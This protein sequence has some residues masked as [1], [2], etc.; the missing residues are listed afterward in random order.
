[1]HPFPDA[2][3]AR[4][5]QFVG[6]RFTDDPKLSP[7]GKVYLGSGPIVDMAQSDN[8]LFDRCTFDLVDAGVLPWSWRATYRDCTMRQRSKQTAMTKG[9]YLGTTTINAPVDLYGSKVL[10]TLMLN[11]KPVQRG[12][13]GGKPW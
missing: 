1:V 6:C 2:D 11:G 7:T 10:G 8:V 12:L 4:A 9:Q 13:H 3:P 5:T